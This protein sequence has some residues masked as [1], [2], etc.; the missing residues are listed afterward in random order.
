M[1]LDGEKS[2]VGISATCDDITVGVALQKV[3]QA[4][5]DDGMI[6]DQHQFDPRR[7][8]TVRHLRASQQ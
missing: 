1:P 6:V 4:L 8:R 7:S 5:Q 2:G 3:F